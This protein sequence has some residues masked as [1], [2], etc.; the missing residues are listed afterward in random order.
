MEL[1]VWLAQN[2]KIETNSTEKDPQ[3]SWCKFR[4]R[5]GLQLL[6]PKLEDTHFLW[7]IVSSE[8]FWA[9]VQE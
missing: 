6:H 5:L 8:F 1:T 2:D 4:R 7:S 9:L 3:K